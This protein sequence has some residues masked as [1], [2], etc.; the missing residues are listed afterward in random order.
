MFVTPESVDLLKGFSPVEQF[1]NHGKTWVIEG[2]TSKN[3]GIDFL[4]KFGGYLC[5]LQAFGKFVKTGKNKVSTSQLRNIFG[6][7]KR[8]ELAVDGDDEKWKKKENDFSLLRPKIAYNVSRV[9]ANEKGSRIKELGEVL[10]LAHKHVD[11]ASAL[12]NFS[13]L[14][15]GI[16]AYHKYFGGK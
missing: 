8:I 10:I 12:R 15:E 7:V 5:D 1:K 9:L 2:L 4:E 13:Q 3:Q 16:L 14:L 11:S 6:E